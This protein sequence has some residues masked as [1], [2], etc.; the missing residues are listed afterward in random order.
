MEKTVGWSRGE[1]G[2]YV[3]EESDRLLAFLLKGVRPEKF[4]YR[5]GIR[6]ALA[7]EESTPTRTETGFAPSD[8]EARWKEGGSLPGGPV[9]LSFHRVMLSPQRPAHPSQVVR[10]ETSGHAPVG[11]CQLKR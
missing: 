10:S 5:L 7:N 6:G 9:S 3:R 11:S 4:R 8:A 1:P 2:G